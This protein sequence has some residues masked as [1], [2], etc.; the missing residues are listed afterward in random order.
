[1]TVLV[2]IGVAFLI[3]GFYGMYCAVDQGKRE[4]AYREAQQAREAAQMYQDPSTGVA[5]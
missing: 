2:V 5:R 4:R 1:M 3:G